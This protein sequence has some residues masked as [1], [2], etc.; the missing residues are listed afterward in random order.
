MRKARCDSG[1]LE[2]QRTSC[3]V[4]KLNKLDVKGRGICLVTN[5]RGSGNCEHGCECETIFSNHLRDKISI[6]RPM[7]CTARSNINYLASSVYNSLRD[8]QSEPG[9]MATA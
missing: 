6:V 3:Y 5:G 4:N 8:T 7:G 1:E 9:V 2:K